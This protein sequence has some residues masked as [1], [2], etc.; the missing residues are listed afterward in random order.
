MTDMLALSTHL[1][2]VEYAPGQAIFVEG[3]PSRAI[4][5]LMSGELEV[6]KGDVSIN[7]INQP[8]ALVGE[9][10]VLLGADHTATVAATEPSRLRIAAD[11]QSLLLGDPIIAALVAVGLAERLNFVN[12]YLVDLKLQY[13]EVPGLAM[14]SDV[15]SRLAQ[16]Q[17]PS[18]RPG[19]ARDPNPEY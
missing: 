6:R 2:E 12:T 11:G 16:R 17:A 18:A 14:I 7:T 8:G 1:P 4:W 10:S 19:S 15:L 13:E 3:E 5:I 9:V